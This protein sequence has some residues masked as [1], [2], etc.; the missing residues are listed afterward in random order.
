MNTQ[1]CI[2]LVMRSSQNVFEVLSK[3]LEAPLH[4][5]ID[6]EARLAQV[7]HNHAALLTKHKSVS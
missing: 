1:L 2:I 7:L 4:T 5:D 6:F 3:A